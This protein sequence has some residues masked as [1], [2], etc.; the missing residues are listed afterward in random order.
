[1]KWWNSLSKLK[2]VLI[3]VLVILIIGVGF[4]ESSED[5]DTSN[6]DTNQSSQADIE[7]ESDKLNE[8]EVSEVKFAFDD[9][10]HV[11]GEDIKPGTYR[12]HGNDGSSLGCYWE[13]LSGFSGEFDEI[14]A[15]GT[16]NSGEPEVVTISNNDA[17]F[18]TQGC[19]KWYSELSQVTDSTTSFGD[20]TFIVGVDVS[21]GTYK[22]SGADSL[23][24]YW[25]RRSGF[26]GEFEELIA[27]ENV[28][29]TTVVTISENDKAFV[30]SG[31]GIWAKT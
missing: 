30:S 11:I 15:N 7:E 6:I 25:E 24:C 2:K 19:G 17:G 10:T 28:E 20:G 9:G 27:N 12:T 29:T 1:M 14:I 22:N 13:R 23:G 31:C 16:K 26:S 21:P 8:A 18:K 5:A 3:I 4:S